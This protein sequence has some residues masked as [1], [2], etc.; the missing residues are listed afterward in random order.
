[1]LFSLL[2]WLGSRSVLSW[3]AS[4]LI[5][6]TMMIIILSLSERNFPR[7][8]KTVAYVLTIVVGYVLIALVQRGDLAKVS[9]PLFGGMVLYLACQSLRTI[10]LGSLFGAEGS[11]E[12]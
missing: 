8:L 2:L 9:K 3:I 12:N 10:I 6:A 7:I 1:L 4:E 5:L 11:K